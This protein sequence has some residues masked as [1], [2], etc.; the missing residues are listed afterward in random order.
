MSTTTGV[1]INNELEKDIMKLCKDDKTNKGKSRLKRLK[2]LTKK[3][4]QKLKIKKNK[5]K[6]KK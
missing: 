4:S 5:S 6:S 2:E 3:F 1:G